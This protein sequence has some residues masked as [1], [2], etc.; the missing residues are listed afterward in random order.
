MKTVTPFRFMIYMVIIIATMTQCAKPATLQGGPEDKSPPSLRIETSTKNQQIHFEKQ[1]IVLEF[2]EFV[3]LK[4]VTSK[5]IVSPPLTYIPSITS[6]GKKV[7]FKFD[8]R[9]VLKNNATYVVNF[10][11]AIVD[12]TEGNAVENYRFVVSTGAYID[13]L[14]IKGNI[15][16][17]KTNEPEKDIIV[18]LY[19]DTRDSVLYLQKPFY[20]AKTDDQGLF[21]I[22]NIRADSFK[23]CAL[24][25]DNL[26]YIYDQDSEWIGFLD[27]LIIVSDS[28]NIN[29][30]MEVF[31]ERLAFDRLGFDAKQYGSVAVLYTGTPTDVRFETSYKDQA[32]TSE[33]IDDSLKVWYRNDVDSAFQIYLTD[34]QSY[35]DTI[36]V[37]KYKLE[38]FRK[39]KTLKLTGNNLSMGNKLGFRDSLKL[40]FNHPITSFMEDSIRLNLKQDTLVARQSEVAFLLDSISPRQ[41]TLLHNWKPDSS[42]TIDVLPDAFIDFFDLANDS[43]SLDFRILSAADYGSIYFNYDS[44]SLDIDYVVKLMED[45]EILEQR[46]IVDTQGKIAFSNLL[47][48]DYLFEIIEDTNRNGEWDPGDYQERKQSE[49]I[50]YK[51]LESLRANWELNVYFRNMQFI[52]SP[53]PIEDDTEDR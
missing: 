31:Q 20:F 52:D 24:R 32:L 21:T 33:I 19:E 41:V 12:Y 2:D 40:E 36:K 34:Q 46:S 53:T 42:Y 43:L 9:E 7:I 8:E 51:S 49:N 44:L 22:E 17:A 6:R 11:D 5:V 18:M 39:K 47:P 27:S 26:N 25:D 15:L 4:D 35:I 10:S 50:I 30:S 1:D 38:D 48:G 28:S 3:E 14:S 37:R 13:S 45:E 16:N 29:L 23:V